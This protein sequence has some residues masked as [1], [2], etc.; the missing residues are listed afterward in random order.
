MTPSARALTPD[1]T[2]LLIRILKNDRAI[3]EALIYQLGWDGRSYE[4]TAYKRLLAARDGTDR[5][6]EKLCESDNV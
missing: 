2:N 4:S 1:M 6:L 5:Q 3:M